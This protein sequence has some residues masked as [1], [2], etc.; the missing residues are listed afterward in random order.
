MPD[1]DIGASQAVLDEICA[2]VPASATRECVAAKLRQATHRNGCSIEDL[3][4]AGRGVLIR[5]PTMWP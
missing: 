4:H 1:M 3:R 5:A 2:D